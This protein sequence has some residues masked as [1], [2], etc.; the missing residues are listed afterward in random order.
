MHQWDPTEEEFDLSAGAPADLA[1]AAEVASR[2][3]TLVYGEQD[4]R[5][6]DREDR[7]GGATSS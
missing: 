3:L 4:E 5:A 2:T 6:H 7:P 1:E